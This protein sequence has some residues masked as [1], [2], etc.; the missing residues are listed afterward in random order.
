MPPFCG[1][2]A[3]AVLEHQGTEDF[4][5]FASGLGDVFEV[6]V[7]FFAEGIEVGRGGGEIS[8]EIGKADV[9]CGTAGVSG[10]FTGRGDEFGIRE[11]IPENFL[12][13]GGA[14]GIPDDELEF[15]LLQV[16]LDAGQFLSGFRT[17]PG[18]T[19]GVEGAACDIS[20]G[21]V[22]EVNEDTRDGFIQTD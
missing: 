10:D 11:G 17:E 5:V 1:D 16:L 19:R 7:G 6:V 15:K 14:P 21:G 4:S 13:P 12:S 2:S 9:N 20:V 8:F 3:E 18:H 22:A